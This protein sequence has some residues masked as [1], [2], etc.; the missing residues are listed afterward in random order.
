MGVLFYFIGFIN[1]NVGYSSRKALFNNL[2]NTP[3]ELLLVGIFVWL[4]VTGE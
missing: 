1:L 2:L 4:C 3:P